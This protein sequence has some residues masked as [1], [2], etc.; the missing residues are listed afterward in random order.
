MTIWFD[1]DGTIADLYGVENW[2]PMIIAS[3]PT[4][5]KQA[6]PL[7]N[8]NR[9]ARKLNRLQQAGYE[10]GVI[11]WLSKNSTPEY[12]EL[13]INAKVKWLNTHLRSVK[14]NK[15]NIVAYGQNKWETCDCEGILFDDE[16]GNRDKWLNNYAFTPDR[17][18]EILNEME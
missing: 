14:W 17:I 4:P 5:Y 2:L 8:M 10:I 13:V 7:V 11:S 15:I 16:Q 12:D 9:L 6:V 1:M 3:D 18:F